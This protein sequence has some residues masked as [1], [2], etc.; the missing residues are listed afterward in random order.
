M[1]LV[2]QG[3]KYGL[4]LDPLFQANRSLATPGRLFE[5]LPRPA[6]VA[7]RQVYARQVMVDLLTFLVARQMQSMIGKVHAQ[8]R[9]T[10]EGS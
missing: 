9:F 1:I 7:S 10:L 3:F 6:A 5:R 2:R 4:E 8:C